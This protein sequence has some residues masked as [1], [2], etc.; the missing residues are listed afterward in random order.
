MS[1]EHLVP[2]KP[3]RSRIRSSN[4][5]WAGT[6]TAITKPFNE[7]EIGNTCVI[8]WAAAC[9]DRPFGVSQQQDTCKVVLIVG[10]AMPILVDFKLI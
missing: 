10:A 6:S 1:Q 4:S 5:V 2:S 3:R 7:N 9:G 8:S